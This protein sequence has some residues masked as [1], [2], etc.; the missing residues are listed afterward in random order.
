MSALASHL[1]PGTRLSQ[2]QF[3]VLRATLFWLEQP[4]TCNTWLL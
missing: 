4:P 2:T 3:Q 1:N